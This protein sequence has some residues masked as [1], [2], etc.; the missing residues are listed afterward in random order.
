MSF[1]T[2]LFMLPARFL[3]HLLLLLLFFYFFLFFLLDFLVTLNL[4]GQKVYHRELFLLIQ[5]FEVLR[6][7][8][9]DVI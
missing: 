5:I 3:F 6:I 9:L 2:I 7:H 4:F 8:P 1:M